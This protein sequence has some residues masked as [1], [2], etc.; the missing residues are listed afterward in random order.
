MALDPVTAMLDIAGKVIDR[1]WPDPAHAARAKLE[2]IKL[3]QLGDLAEIVGQLEINKAGGR[4]ESEPLHLRMAT[5]HRLD[6]RRGLR[7]PVR[8]W[9]GGRVGV[10]ASQAPGQVPADG[11]RGHD[12]ALVR[13]AGF[14]GIPTAEKLRGVTK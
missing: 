12:A 9:A 4:G 13:D 8:R 2:P 1:L 6:L 10:R 11:P 7:G 14:R 5:L 3:Q